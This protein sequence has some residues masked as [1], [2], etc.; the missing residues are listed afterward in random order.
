MYTWT[1]IIFL[2]TY[3]IVLYI[4]DNSL[5]F[6]MQWHTVV[7][8][9]TG[10]LCPRSKHSH[11]SVCLLLVQSGQSVETWLHPRTHDSTIC[12]AKNNVRVRVCHQFIC[13]SSW[14]AVN[15]VPNWSA[16]V[17]LGSWRVEIT[18]LKWVG[19]LSY[20]EILLT[21]HWWQLQQKWC[22]NYCQQHWRV[23]CRPHSGQSLAS[24]LT[25]LLSTRQSSL[26]P[27]VAFSVC[28]WYLTIAR[29]CLTLETTD[30]SLILC[31][32]SQ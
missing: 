15:V 1:W 5:T 9:G 12:C 26:V 19:N 17:H 7:Y 23:R 10:E 8:L 14:V 18:H 21:V 32:F 29:K 11:S 4:T 25:T 6:I 13:E 22:G 30:C 24:N 20:S 16:D 28:N 2:P 27:T 31:S 3:I